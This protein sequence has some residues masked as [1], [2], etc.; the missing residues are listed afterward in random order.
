MTISTDSQQRIDAYLNILRKRLRGLSDEDSRDIV[1]E[2]RSHVLD[3]AAIGGDITPDAVVSALAALGNP[4]AL[5]SQYVTDD[6]LMRAQVA[7]SPWLILRSLFRW[8][9]LSVA[10]FCILMLSLI[11]YG[12][13]G[14]LVLCALL[15]PFHPQTDG[16]WLLN[17]PQDPHSFS[18][19]LGFSSLSVDG[20]EVLGWWIV[21]IGL[22]LGAWLGLL[23]FYSGRWSI[24]QF[25]R[26]LRSR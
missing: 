5:A 7:R 3:K 15:K 21:P 22:A 17:S 10:G 13:A 16:L 26:P 24:R 12:L 23:T 2:I 8:A 19:H 25:W 18:L 1:E 4:E 20:R 9:G 14:S 11:G 6:L